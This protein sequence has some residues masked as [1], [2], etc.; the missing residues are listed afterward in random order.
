MSGFDNE[1]VYAN[2]WDFRGVQPV[3]PQVSSSGQ[4]PIGTGGSPAI[5]V[6]SLTSPNGTLTIGYSSPNITLDLSGGT[7]A[8]DSIAVDTTT[9]AGTNPVVPTA[10]G[11]LTM[12]GGQY[13]T[14]TFGTRVI[15]INSSAANSLTVE[16]QISSAVASTSITNNGLS[17]FDSADFTVD[18][19]GFVSAATTGF[20]KTLTG[21]SGG[22]RSPTANNINILGGTSSAGT[23]PV[24]VAGASSTLTVNIQ[25][26]QAIASTD[27]TKIGLSSFSS[28]NFAVDSN[29]FVTIIGGGFAWSDTSGTVTAAAENGYFITTTCTS[30]LPASP[31]EGDT[32]K[33]IVD[34]TNL[35]TITAAGS[36]KI[37]F[38]T[39]LSA[40]GGT[41]VNTQRGD[42]VVLVYRTSGTTWF[43]EANP[44]GAWN[45]T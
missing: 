38:G 28:S 40:A 24:A 16:A 15:T 8:I 39:T 42:S 20:I 11:L 9:G 2:N 35:L 45:I 21:D 3:L 29:G 36:Q 25:K 22:A 43:C 5:L 7:I 26:S 12:T 37:R 44:V 33:Y 10:A 6:G 4:L 1:T 27:A 18:A 31:S 34:T 14:G 41:A 19:N 30:T 32:V 23:T 17:H 13:P